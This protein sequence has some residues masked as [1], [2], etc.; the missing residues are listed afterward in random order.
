MSDKGIP[1][2]TGGVPENSGAPAELPADDQAPAADGAELSPDAESAVTIKNSLL[3]SAGKLNA[4]AGPQPPQHWSK[5]D[6]DEFLSHDAKGREWLLKRHQSMEGDYTRRVQA[7]AEEK[8]RYGQFDEIFAPH[9]DRLAATGQSEADVVRNVIAAQ[10]YLEQNP[11]E[12]LKWLAQNLGVDLKTLTIDGAAAPA[13]ADGDPFDALD[14][15]IANVLK[16]VMGDV[17]AIKQTFEQQQV[18]ARNEAARGLQRSMT[19]FTAAKNEAGEPAYP[20]LANDEVRNTMAALIRTG[21]V[22][23]EKSGGIVPALKVAYDRAVYAVPS[24]REALVQSEW[25]T[26]QKKAAGA[27]AERVK[28]ARRAGVSLSGSGSSGAASSDGKSIKDLLKEAAQER[29][30]AA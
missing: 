27:S 28:Q 10:V 2:E 18:T 3:E 13:D 6:K 21:Q 30:F 17:G 15:K 16:G 8:R 20:H 19:E 1:S 5:A 25:E 29:G 11:V 4:D 7:L 22:D 9:K 23:I 24:T 26:R 14:P 12:G